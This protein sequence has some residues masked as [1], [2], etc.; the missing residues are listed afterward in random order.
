M[1][2]SFRAGFLLALAV[3]SP[4]PVSAQELKS[5]A[6]A[7]QLASALD[8]A[9]LENVAAA[10]PANPGYFVGALYLGGG[11]LLVVTAKFPVPE[12]LDHKIAAKE[13]RDVYLDLGAGAATARIFIEDMG[14]NGLSPKRHG[15]D[16]VDSIDIEGKRV[17]LDGQ[18]GK[19]KLSSEEYQSAFSSADARYVQMLQALLAQLKKG[20]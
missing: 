11:Q 18:P 2:L 1:T 12:A 20:T 9:K 6:L 14:A 16:L 4:V 10:D 15:D 7:K 19:Q 17:I 3:L 8:A 13:Y 5:E